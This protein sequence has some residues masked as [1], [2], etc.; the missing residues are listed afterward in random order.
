MC[1]PMSSVSSRTSLPCPIICF[2]ASITCQ[3]LPDNL[4]PGQ[5]YLSGYDRSVVIQVDEYKRPTFEVRFDPYKEA[6]TMGDSVRVSAE[7]KGIG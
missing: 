7:A 1:G 3:A 5:Y 6:Y 2:R 4:L